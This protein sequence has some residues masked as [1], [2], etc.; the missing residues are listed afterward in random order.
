[1]QKHV[2]TV[3]K[4]ENTLFI[5]LTT[6]Q[7]S[8]KELATPLAPL[9][10]IQKEKSGSKESCFEEG[11]LSLARRIHKPSTS[12][13]LLT[14][15]MQLHSHTTNNSSLS[16][17]RTPRLQNEKKKKTLILQTRHLSPSDCRAR[18]GGSLKVPSRQRFQLSANS[19]E[20]LHMR[21]I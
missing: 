18:C 13:L 12:L 10:G 14:D 5:R 2:T 7:I 11:N 4:I 8:P 21:S 19:D 20:R 15:C 17:K 16:F 1:M 3:K 9:L 6:P